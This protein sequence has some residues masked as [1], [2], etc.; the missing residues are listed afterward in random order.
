MYTNSMLSERN[1][2]HDYAYNLIASFLLPSFLPL[3]T[4]D[5]PHGGA[6]NLEGIEACVMTR[7]IN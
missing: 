5:E 4:R 2:E 7:D 3:T 6:W 1:Q